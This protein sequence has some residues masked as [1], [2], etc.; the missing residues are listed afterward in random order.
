MVVFRAK[1]PQKKIPIL[2]RRIKEKVDYFKRRT[3][4]ISGFMEE[5]TSGLFSSQKE[6]LNV[7]WK[8]YYGK[9]I[10]LS[11]N[12]ESNW[13][14]PFLIPSPFFLSRFGIKSPVFVCISPLPYFAERTAR[15]VT[16]PS[17][18]VG[19]H[20]APRQ[21]ITAAHPSAGN[22]ST[23]PARGAPPLQVDF[24]KTLS[25]EQAESFLWSPLDTP[26]CAKRSS[27]QPLARPPAPR[28]H[29]AS[30]EWITLRINRPSPSLD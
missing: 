30:S 29:C 1:H 8:S 22:E 13:R 18:S 25:G 5:M 11:F 20:R 3:L 26:G 19:R 17:T 10:S 7:F 23:Y 6:S 12:V 4:F 14:C 16:R 2:S 21:S 9:E 27:V 24:A 15:Y 28:P